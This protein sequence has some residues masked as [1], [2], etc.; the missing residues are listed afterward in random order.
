MKHSR[1]IRHPG[2]GVRSLSAGDARSGSLAAAIL[3]AQQ[4]DGCSLFP[5]DSIWNVRVDGLPLDAGSA[6][7]VGTIGADIGL[8]P[9]FG[10]GDWPP[11]SGSPIGIPFDSVASS[12][13]P[14]PI[15][16]L[17]DDESDP[18]PYPI[19]PDASIEGG[20]AS[21]GD[22]HVLVLE[23]GSCTL[24]E[25]FRRPSHGRRHLVERRLGRRLPA[26]LARTAAGGLDLG[27]RGRTADPARAG[28]LRRDRGR[29]HR[30]RA[31]LHGAADS[32][33]VRLAGET[34][35]LVAHREPLSADGPAL[36]PARR[37]RPG[38]LLSFGAGHP[39]G[40][41]GVR[42]DAGRQRLGLV[43]LRS[44]RRA[45]GQRRVGGARRGE[46]LGLRG[47]RRVV[48]DGRSGLS[49]HD[50]RRAPPRPG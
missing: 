46:G 1:R 20:P 28:A 3:R 43:H 38:R 50:A 47:G 19:P 29:A 32:E 35:R 48:P 5:A 33:G 25:L 17:Y 41:Q 27:R 21:D 14:V 6:S 18:G 39:P 49:S 15:T 42:H 22:R 31:A 23:S 2:S 12:Q 7:Y 44:A 16:F 36:P 26:R 37:L 4:I 34:L 13:P 45:L 24:Y 30:A 9:D 10:S 11:G 40:A 8:H